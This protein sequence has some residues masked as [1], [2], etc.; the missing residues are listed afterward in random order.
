VHQ[1]EISTPDARRAGQCLSTTGG[2]VS[3]AQ[4][5]RSQH[6]EQVLAVFPK[7]AGQV[8][9]HDAGVM[10]LFH[11]TNYLRLWKCHK[12]SADRPV[13]AVNVGDF[14]AMEMRNFSQ[15]EFFRAGNGNAPT[16]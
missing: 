4:S 16:G 15:P 9:G 11:R 1:V 14:A 3:H 8:A 5:T 6:L 2:P 13:F 10:V 7:P 12:R